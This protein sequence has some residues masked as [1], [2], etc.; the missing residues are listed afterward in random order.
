MDGPPWSSYE[1]ADA[2][3][4]PVG[5]DGAVVAYRATASRDGGE[6]TALFAS[7][8]VRQAGRWRL[9]VHQQTPV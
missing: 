7:T 4:L 1:L 6:Y 8:Y 3:V 5:Q 9:A 2:R